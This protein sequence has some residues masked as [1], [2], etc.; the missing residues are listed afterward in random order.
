MCLERSSSSECTQEYHSIGMNSIRDTAGDDVEVD[1]CCVE[2]PVYE[3]D[4]VEVE[5]GD[6][7]VVVG[8]CR[9]LFTTEPA[10]V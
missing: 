6:V 10:T 4:F 5:D 8:V 7:E 2:L 1:V 3:V 9:G